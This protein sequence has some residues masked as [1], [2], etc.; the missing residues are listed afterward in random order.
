[1]CGRSQPPSPLCR[2]WVAPACA[3]MQVACGQWM[4]SEYDVCLHGT[5]ESVSVRVF[6]DSW[7]CGCS[8]SS[9]AATGLA[10]ARV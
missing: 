3:I 8:V 7:R 10:P 9:C 6:E 4:S 1:M 2:S 5:N